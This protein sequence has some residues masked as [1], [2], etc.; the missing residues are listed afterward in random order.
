M[1]N[2]LK[3]SISE[4]LCYIGGK[5]KNSTKLRRYYKAW[6]EK[7][8]PSIPERC[9]NNQCYFYL[10]PLIWNGQKLKLILDHRNGVNSDD[11][12]KNL[13]FLCPNCDSQNNITR[14][15]ANKGRIIKFKGGFAIK[16]KN[17]KKHYTMPVETGNFKLTGNDINFKLNRK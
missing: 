8:N 6:R 17:G 15:G 1:K 4:I 16:D 13:Q 3:F 2:K 11:R 12:P 10:N 5:R 9:D 14:G 7:Q